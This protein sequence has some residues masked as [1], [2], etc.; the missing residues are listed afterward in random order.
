LFE[1]VEQIRK[2]AKA[3]RANGN[4]DLELELSDLVNLLPIDDMERVARAF[5]IYFDL[6][7][8]A[9]EHHRIRVLRERER[10]AHP[11]QL[12][13]ESIMAAVAELHRLGVDEPGMAKILANLN[14]ELVFTAHPTQVKRR[15]IFSK[16]RRIAR[17]L[18]DI[19]IRD[20][21]QSERETLLDAIRA[22]ITALWVTERGRTTKPTVPDEVRTGLYYFNNTLWEV[23]PQVYRSLARALSTYY[24]GLSLP[25][26][27]LTFGS[28]IGGDRDGNPF[29]TAKITAQTLQ[30]HRRLAAERHEVVARPLSR[31][32]SISNRLV[33]ISP[34]LLAT[35]EAYEP[36]SSSHLS[37]LSQRYPHETYR[38]LAVMLRDQLADA[39]R[40]DV[41]AQLGEHPPDTLPILRTREDLLKPLKLMDSSLRDSGLK[42]IADANLHA[43][44]HQA[45]TFGMHVAR[46]D[47]RQYSEYNLAVLDELFRKLGYTDH[48]AQLDSANRTELLTRLLSEWPP[49]LNQL[50]DLSPEATETLRLFRLMRRT[51]E[52]YG[53]EALG[54][55]I[56]SM[57]RGPDDILAVLLL[58]RW[59]GLCMRVDGSQ[60]EG[61]SIVPLFET[62]ADLRT[63]AYV[64][65]QLFKHP[66]Y[67]QHLKQWDNK[68]VIMIGYSDSN[69][70]AGYITAKWELYQAQEALAQ[71]CQSC[72]VHLTLFHGRGGTI[73]RGGGP[74]N[75]AILAQPPGSVDGQIRI[76]EQGEVIDER[77]GHPAIARRHLEQVIH[78][79]LMTSAPGHTEQITP[80]PQWRSAMDELAAT[81]Y[82]AYRSLV[83]ETP[84]LLEYWQQATPINEISQLEIGSRPASRGNSQE[85][86]TLRAIPWGF[87]WMQSRHAL[88]GWYGLGT[89]IESY[90]THPEQFTLL[91]EM[92][93]QWPFFQNNIDNAQVAMG[94]ADMGIARLYANLVEDERVR[95]L[96]FGFILDEFQ[97]TRQAILKITQQKEILDNE[98][99]LQRSIRLRNP[100][101]DPLNFIQVSL[102]RK[103]RALPD[104]DGDDAQPIWEGVVLTI[105]GIAAG[106]KN[107]G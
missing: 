15:S 41:I 83:Y 51:V 47:I 5:T 56:V 45:S 55:Y 64:M 26:S 103:L 68:Q 19:E 99:V 31:M 61:I 76:T 60:Q 27:F 50:S 85:I 17:S 52:I 88:P 67:S 38:L 7:N 29:V 37:Y 34:K 35:L 24:P 74:T 71:C 8:L 100:Y 16:L 87:S 20:L 46:L 107:T 93:Q 1:T 65:D 33:E 81:G 9:E 25:A 58:A 40:D 70:D 42:S 10:E 69:K 101:V 78:A 44:Y 53:P 102:L 18:Y 11:E 84:E 80:R 12:L 73:A 30:L 72:G 22:E 63:A 21:L 28:W 105:N 95:E 4:P 94:K 59:V 82:N 96:I 98:P 89:A 14:I 57:T 43:F 106:L 79:M 91:Q 36:G 39:A 86:N 23:I 90:A 48:Y 66:A 62:R 32:L 92:Y 104:P 6:V 13:D 49:D 2:L 3:R 97:R 77:Y 75:R 54:P